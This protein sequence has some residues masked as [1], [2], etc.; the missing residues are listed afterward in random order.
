MPGPGQGQLGGGFP[1]FR[2]DDSTKKTVAGGPSA[3]H[4]GKDG[5]LRVYDVFYALAAITAGQWVATDRSA[6]DPNGQ[7]RGMKPSATADDGE[8]LGVADE[9][10]AINTWGK[11][12]VHGRRSCNVT[13]GTAAGALLQPSAVAGVAITAAA[14][15]DRACGRALAAE[16]A[17]VAE[18]NVRCLGA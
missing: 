1:E 13:A 7:K 9:A 15:T 5:D 16:A 14:L 10:V 11:V 4:S 18:C 6:N 2:D 17:G 3:P 12:L 8:I